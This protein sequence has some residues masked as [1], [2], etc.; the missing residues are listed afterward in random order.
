MTPDL[1]LAGR[2][3]K[4]PLMPLGVMRLVFITLQL[5]CELV[6]HMAQIV[7]KCPLQMARA[8]S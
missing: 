2:H 8:S 5:V 1:P 3:K 7:S 4:I 6:R